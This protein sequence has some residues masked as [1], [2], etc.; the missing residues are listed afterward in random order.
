MNHQPKIKPVLTSGERMMELLSIVMLGIMWLLVIFYFAKLPDPVPVHFDA[1]GEPDAYGSKTISV[2]LPI[3][4]G[5]LFAGMTI[6]NRYPHIFNYPVKI[7][8]ENARRQYSFATRLVRLL[9]L[10]IMFVF[11]LI[12]YFM[13]RTA[14]GQSAGL[15]VWFLPV[16]LVLINVPVIYYIVLAIRKK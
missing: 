16:F 6:I 11:L 8:P 9:K 3:I 1:K 12:E 15:G 10:V 13:F 2:F 5:L 7:T 14:L 4:A